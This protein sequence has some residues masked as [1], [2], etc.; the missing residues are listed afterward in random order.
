MKIDAKNADNKLDGLHQVI[1][2]DVTGQH[3]DICLSVP[4]LLGI[5]LF[6]DIDL[7]LLFSYLDHPFV[8]LS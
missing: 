7:K 6:S 2:K 3:A 4:G 5:G 8:G 1:D